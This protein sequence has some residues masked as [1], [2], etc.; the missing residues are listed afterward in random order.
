MVDFYFVFNASKIL[1]KFTLNHSNSFDN[2]TVSL[3]EI[4]DLL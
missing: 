1:S 2:I 4:Y 3:P